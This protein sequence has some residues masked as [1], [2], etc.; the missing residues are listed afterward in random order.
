[1]SKETFYRKYDK[2]WVKEIEII[3]YTVNIEIE[4]FF[5]NRIDLCFKDARFSCN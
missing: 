4:I 2:N 1:M 3:K 5:K